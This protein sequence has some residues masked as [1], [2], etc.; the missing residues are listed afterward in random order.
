MHRAAYL[1]LFHSRLVR[2]TGLFKKKYTLSVI[3]F[4]KTTDA[5]SMPCERMERKSLKVLIWISRQ[6]PAAH[7][8][9]LS[10]TGSYVE[11]GKSWIIDFTLPHHT[12]G[13]H[14]VLVRCGNNF[15]SSPF[16]L[17]IAHRHMF[18]STCKIN[19][20]KFILI[21]NNPVFVQHSALLF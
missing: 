16:S 5:K 10:A 17:Y 1:Y 20:W 15:E 9:I 19:F 11:C 21:F 12:W 6:V 18:N 14:R 2:S 4:T 8:V 3:Y 13:S 7:A